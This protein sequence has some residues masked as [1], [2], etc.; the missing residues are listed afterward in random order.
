VKVENHSVFIR[1]KK[2]GSNRVR[3]LVLDVM[4]FMRRFLEHVLP[5]GFMK[6][7]YYTRLAITEKTSRRS[8]LI[9]RQR[10]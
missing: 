4:E 2:S 3:T 9:H 5:T 1:Y 10:S 6:V 8:I 7:R